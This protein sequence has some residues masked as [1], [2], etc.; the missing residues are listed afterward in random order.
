MKVLSI[1]DERRTVRRRFE[2]I[3]PAPEVGVYVEVVGRY[4]YSVFNRL[5]HLISLIP[6]IRD[7]E[8]EATV[9]MHLQTCFI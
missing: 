7:A 9:F 8:E 1:L 6:R 3:I 4:Q 2:V 5:M